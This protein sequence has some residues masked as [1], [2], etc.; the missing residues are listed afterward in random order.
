MAKPDQQHVRITP[1]G[2]L[3]RDKGK[4]G[5][6]KAFDNLVVASGPLD[7]TASG[8]PVRGLYID[9]TTSGIAIRL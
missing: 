1:A 9:A 6:E 5:L 7:A 3:L 2:E 8:V 4:L